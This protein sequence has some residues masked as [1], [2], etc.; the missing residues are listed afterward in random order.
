MTL[1]CALVAALPTGTHLGRLHRLWR[2]VRG[3]LLAARG[4][5][6]AGLAAGELPARAVRRAWAALGQGRW[7]SARLLDDWAALVQAEG[8]WRAHAHGGYRPV[9]VDVTAC[10]RPRLRGGPT[11]RSH[12]AARRALPAVPPGLVAR[13]GSAGGQRLA[14]PLAV[15][16]AD[17]GDPSA[18]AQARRLVREA[19]RRCAADDALVLDAGFGAALRQAEGASRYAVRVARNA[20]F[21]R[22]TPPAY[23]GRGRPPT[24][25]A[26]VRPL[27]R[28]YKGRPIPATAPDQRAT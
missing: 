23:G 18:A 6:F 15:V 9:A 20:T 16:R 11:S 22:A 7:T 8:R 14:L 2:L 1:L 13:V 10:G 25:G 27:P 21:R 24:R 28:T 4:A 26:V 17:A 5:L 12:G 19:A 3:R